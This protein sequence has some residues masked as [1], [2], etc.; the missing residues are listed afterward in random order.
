MADTRNTHGCHDCA[1]AKG[2]GHK[3]DLSS[4]ITSVDE[5]GNC[6]QWKPA[7]AAPAKPDGVRRRTDDNL[8]R[9]FA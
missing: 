2:R 9:V 3:C 6:E 4:W 1:Y 8:K 5:R 7:P